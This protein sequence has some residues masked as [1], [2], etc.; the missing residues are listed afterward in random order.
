MV[1]HFLTGVAGG[2]SNVFFR[3]ADAQILGLGF[4][5]ML[6]WE[7]GEW[8]KGI[9]ESLTNRVLDIVVGLA[10][11]WAALIVVRRAPSEGAYIVLGLAAATATLGALLGARARLRRAASDARPP[12]NARAPAAPAPRAPA[13][14]PPAR[15][16]T[17]P[18]DPPN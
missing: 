18:S 3:L 5:M 12:T 14:H 15:P 6:A 11:A 17:R 13:P 8:I 16:R 1:V 7:I 2:A 10:G 4:L 9:R